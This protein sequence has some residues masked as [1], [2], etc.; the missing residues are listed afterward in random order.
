MDREMPSQ[1]KMLALRFSFVQLLLP[2]DTNSR[3]GF[4]PKMLFYNE[5][6]TGPIF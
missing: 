6:Y 1:T 3:A 4:E 2:F 5:N